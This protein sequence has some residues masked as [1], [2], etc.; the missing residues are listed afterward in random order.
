VWLLGGELKHKLTLPILHYI[1]D[2]K[3]ITVQQQERCN[4]GREVMRYLHQAEHAK[5][6]NAKGEWLSARI[7]VVVAARQMS[8]FSISV[9][10]NHTQ[11]ATRN[12][13]HATRSTQH[14]TQ[15]DTCK[16]TASEHWYVLFIQNIHEI[17]AINY[18]IQC[19]AT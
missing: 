9:A 18:N 10:R 5:S 14:A 16:Y 19:Y 12:T 13:Q 3:N 17:C 8:L 7:D 15:H 1:A 4:R 6:N 2:P 11:H